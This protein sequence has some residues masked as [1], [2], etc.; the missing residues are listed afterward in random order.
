MRWSFVKRSISRFNG[1]SFDG[2]EVLFS[3]ALA[4]L[5]IATYLMV[6]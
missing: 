6:L 1:V 3:G 5:V 4:D 2:V